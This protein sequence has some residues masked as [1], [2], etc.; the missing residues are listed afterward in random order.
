MPSKLQLDV[1]L[2]FLYICLQKSDYKTIDFSAVGQAANINPPA[3]RMRFTRLKKA[4]ESGALNSSTGTSLVVEGAGSMPLSIGNRKGK[5]QPN[6]AKRAK[7]TTKSKADK[8]QK[9]RLRKP[10]LSFN[11]PHWISLIRRADLFKQHDWWRAG[12]LGDCASKLLHWGR[13]GWLYPPTAG[14]ST[15]IELC[16]YA[17]PID[18]KLAATGMERRRSVVKSIPTIPG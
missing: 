4:I 14:R 13:L 3:A 15:A 8:T 16:K 5:A 2:W 18:D 10:E 6:A 7:A 1:N 9:D 17:A 11:R 12:I